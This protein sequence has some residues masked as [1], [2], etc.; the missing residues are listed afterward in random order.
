MQRM[1]EKTSIITF[2][3]GQGFL[4]LLIPDQ[5]LVLPWAHIISSIVVLYVFTI[6][7][8]SRDEKSA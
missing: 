4:V 7:A 2:Y 1:P 3:N 8:E 6:A 5:R